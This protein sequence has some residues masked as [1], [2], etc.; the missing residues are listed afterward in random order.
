MRLFIYIVALVVMGVLY[1]GASTTYAQIFLSDSTATVQTNV[2]ELPDS[3]KPIHWYDYPEVELRALDK[4][5]AQST[6]FRVKVGKPAKFGKIYMKVQACRKPQAIDKL[7]SAAFIQVWEKPPTAEKSKWVFSGW[8]FASSPS[9]SAM[10]HPIYDVWLIDCIGP[11]PDPEDIEAATEEETVA[12]ELE[13]DNESD[14]SDTQQDGEVTNTSADEA[15][16]SESET[17]ANPNSTFDTL[18]DSLGN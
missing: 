1:A 18:L 13:V 4:I 17:P 7:D 9:L 11:D 2:T 15:P 6:T 8:M 16:A 10:D 14:M 5:T 3:E 12:E